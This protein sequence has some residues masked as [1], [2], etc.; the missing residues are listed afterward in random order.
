MET[1]KPEEK[2]VSPT[3]NID[4]Y[5]RKAELDRLDEIFQ[6]ARATGKVGDK[7]ANIPIE[8]DKE[9]FLYRGGIAIRKSNDKEW[10]TLNAAVDKI[11][12][13]TGGLVSCYT[14]TE[15]N[16]EYSNGPFGECAEYFLEDQ[17]S[18]AMYIYV[19]CLEDLEE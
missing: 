11:N 4:L 12:K 2:I 18:N 9:G 6:E 15:V 1:F 10:P 13:E 7:F 19:R 3:I 8:F 14:L 5:F 17:E 16:S